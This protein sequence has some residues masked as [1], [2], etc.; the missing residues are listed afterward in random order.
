MALLVV[1]LGGNA[2]LRPGERGTAAEQ[3][4]HLDEVAPAL[5]ALVLGG[6]RLVL[7]H[8][9]GPQVG[10]LLIQQE[11]AV[12]LVPPMPLDV[13]GAETQGLIGYLIQ[14]R[15]WGALRA[16]GS[17]V[18]VATVVTQ[19]LV[20][21]TD[22]AFTNPTKPVGPFFSPER[23]RG[24]MVERNWLIREDAGRGWRR[25]VPSPEPLRILEL[26]AVRALV[27]AGAVVVCA[28]GGG[29]PVCEREG[30]LEGCEA[31]IDKDL[32]SA[33]LAADLGADRL[34]ILTDVERVAIRY[35]RPD[36]E[37]LGRVP[38]GRLRRLQAEGHFPP[39]SMGPKVESACRFVERTGREAVIGHLDDAARAAEG[40]AGTV[41]VPDEE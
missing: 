28:G 30:R 31:V 25:I 14:S 6:H 20:S 21:A 2:L 39:G 40:V 3:A 26:D 24:F 34:V 23:A 8:G 13:C 5:A 32:A 1:A 22:P 41:V 10:N 19:V 4:R 17:H 35:G 38:V 9:N 33:L 16:A 29:V 37:R 18:P 12:R 36:E 11:E 15:L 27:E 7:T